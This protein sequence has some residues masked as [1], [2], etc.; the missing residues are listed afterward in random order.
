MNTHFYAQ[1]RMLDRDIQR[2]RLY[3]H[4]AGL[5]TYG[6]DPTKCAKKEWRKAAQFLQDHKKSFPWAIGILW[7][8]NHIHVVDF[9]AYSGIQ[10]FQ[11]W[12]GNPDVDYA[13]FRAGE[14]QDKA[15]GLTCEDGLIALGKEGQHRRGSQ[16]LEKYLLEA[17]YFPSEFVKLHF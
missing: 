9:F 8:E 17:P 13:Q 16:S 7:A 3:L 15:K 2:G 1:I 11:E 5:P 4:S 12:P 14:F 6:D 10:T